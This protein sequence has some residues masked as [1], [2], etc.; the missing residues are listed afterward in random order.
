MQTSDDM[1]LV[2][3]FAEQ[4]N[5]GA[6][7]ALVTRHVNLVY[8]AALRQVGDA[9][10]A[11]EVTQAVFII[12]ARKAGSLRRETFLTGWLFKTTRYAAA[13]ERRA[14]VRRLQR[15]TQAYM[16]NSQIAEEEAWPQ[17]APLL[18]EALANLG[19]TD[20]RAVLLRYFECKTLAEVGATLG[21]N[22]DAARKRVNRGLE[23]LRKLFSKRG[24][25]LTAAVIASVVGAN[26]VQAAP[27][28]MAVKL[29][30][31]AAKGTAM[32]ISTA[33]LVHGTLKT[34]AWAKYKTFV[35][36]V[37]T[38]LIAG[39][40]AILILP[41][42][43]TLPPV[44]I[45]NPTNVVA[46]V[47]E[48]LAD[49]ME[50][51]LDT[52]PGG[53]AIQPDGKIVVGTTL[54]GQ[55]IDAKSGALGFYSRGAL[56]LNPDGS[57][58][59]NFLCD[60][61]RSDSAA[62]QAKVNIATNGEI[63][64]SGVFDFVGKNPMPG[65][66]LLQPDGKLDESFEPWRGSTNHPGITGL[67]AGVSK[68]SWLPD[69]SIGIMSKSVEQTNVNFP[70]Y[71]P[72]AY[73]LDHTGRWIK[74]PTN[75]LA[76]T[77]SRPSGL[78][79]TLG[80]VGFWAR[81]TVDWTNAAPAS[82]RPPIRYGSQTLT[83]ADSPP[84]SDMPFDNWTQ[85]PSATYAAKVFQ[86]LFE[87]V[88]VELC[89]YAVRLP[90]GGTILA[91]RDRVINGSMIAP[92]RFMRFDKNWLPDFS[93]TNSYE[94]D[95]RS[96]LRIKRQPDG[97]FLV[98][99]L[100]GKMNGEDFPGLVRLNES[101]EID[102]SFNCTTTNSWQGRIM[103]MVVQDDGRIVIC[104]FFSTVNGVEVPHIARLNP[105]GSLDQTFK[106]P[107]ITV[108]QFD[109]DRFDKAHRFP[110]TQLT[111][112]TATNTIASLPKTILITS[113]RMDGDAAAIQYSGTPHQQYILQANDSPNS[114]S[115]SNLNTSQSDVNGNGNFRD[116]DAINHATRFYR[117]ATP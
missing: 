53:L 32:A 26:S 112:I 57:L 87:E 43:P 36:Y 111:K 80:S 89:R 58:D 21:V 15:E 2:R 35:A 5:E 104:G 77:F 67:P 17:I 102:R 19:E 46:V 96:E 106:P 18:D 45:S 84:V 12:L 1:S 41:K 3:D 69:G 109:R 4:Q 22:E 71:P 61:G 88:P 7:E 8:S 30:M 34:L 68:T 64:L 115:W 86:A 14:R 62:Q 20:R 56:R 82:P 66:A 55:F 63:L 101:G 95:L 13:A 10:T 42:K 100:V 108:E 99:G 60:V 24:V 92:G 44:Q 114:G 23:K 49:I 79:T 25:T 33:G 116:A 105:D 93:F 81:R 47:S 38:A 27:V 76:A 107:F 11:E 39:T 59:R 51:T 31:I 74:P 75:V 72:T 16:D 50:F 54:F 85:T 40:A 48:P 78:I 110:V 28:G 103:D 9:H 91:I 6:F 37:T 65:Y 73:R 97:K 98:A 29:S 117:I 83:I 52:P 94:A 70:D 90:D 113:I